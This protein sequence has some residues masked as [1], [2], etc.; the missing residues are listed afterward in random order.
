LNPNPTARILNPSAL[1]LNP[2]FEMILL[3]ESVSRQGKHFREKAYETKFDVP[4][5][6]PQ[7]KA[8]LFVGR[9]KL[10]PSCLLSCR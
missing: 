10:V 6:N 3:K 7:E 1:T 9:L 4:R 2:I 5:E 8:K